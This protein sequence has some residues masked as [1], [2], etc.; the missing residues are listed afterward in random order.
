MNVNQI[1]NSTKV[2][3]PGTRYVV[4]LQGCKFNCPGCKNINTHSFEPNILLSVDEI[5]NDIVSQN[6]LTGVTFSG[7][8]PLMQYNELLE[9][10]KRI[11]LETKLDVMLYT[12]YYINEIR[13]L[14]MNE[15]LDYVDI[16]IDGRFEIENF[17][18]DKLYGSSNQTI[19]TEKYNIEEISKIETAEIIISQNGSVTILGNI[20]MLDNLLL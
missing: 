19:I 15:I 14:N 10:I 18:E 1:V 2:V 17:T 8:E 5:F 7:G 13:K 4:W 11:K 9:L 12:G 6:N 20:K 16:L 3:G